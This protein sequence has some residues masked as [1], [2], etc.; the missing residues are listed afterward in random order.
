MKLLSRGHRLRIFVAGAA[1][2]L[3]LLSGGL[4]H[5]R[6][7]S[8]F[9][10]WCYDDPIIL[11]DGVPQSITVGIP[12]SDVSHLIGPVVVTVEAPA[13]HT[14]TLGAPLPGPFQVLTNI[15]PSSNHFSTS[16]V[17]RTTTI[18]PADARFN[19]TVTVV[20]GSGQSKTSSGQSW[21]P[22]HTDFNPHLNK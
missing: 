5:A 13:G 10:V 20:D 6:S 4:A 14:V 11:V 15:I 3:L 12:Q 1:A 22:I 8:A 7:T 18:V 2:G 21:M 16:P 19:V 17:V 9:D